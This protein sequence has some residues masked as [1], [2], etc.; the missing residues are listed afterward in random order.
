MND[1]VGGTSLTC[2]HIAVLTGI[3]ATVEMVFNYGGRLDIGDSLG[4]K[5]LH[6]AVMRY[7]D[8]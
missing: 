2:M 3:V 4:D 8:V 5:P 7:T 6:L 1:T